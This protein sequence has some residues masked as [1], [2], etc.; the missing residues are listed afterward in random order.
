[1]SRRNNARVDRLWEAGYLVGMRTIFNCTPVPIAFYQPNENR[2]N[3]LSKWLKANN[4]DVIIAQDYESVRT[5]LEIKQILVP[6][7][8]NIVFLE[9]TNP[10]F[11]YIDQRHQ[12]IGA[13]AVSLLVG[14]LQ[15][16]EHGLPATPNVTLLRGVWNS[17]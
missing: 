1:M 17:G 10:G 7:D 3:V 12:Q 4:L 16:N 5:S 6:K 2:E 11:A 14:A 15:R 13:T 8:C 9:E